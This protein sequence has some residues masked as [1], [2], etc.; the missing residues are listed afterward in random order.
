[1]TAPAMLRADTVLEAYLHAVLTGVAASL[2]D[3]NASSMVGRAPLRR[4]LTTFRWTRRRVPHGCLGCGRGRR[5]RRRHAGR[6]EPLLSSKRDGR[7]GTKA[8][9]EARLNTVAKGLAV[10]VLGGGLVAGGLAMR[11]SLLEG[12]A[13]GAPAASEGPVPVAVAPV[14]RGPIE[15][16]RELTGTL[17]PSAELVVASKVGGRIKRI[18]VDLGDVVQRG[19]VVAALDDEEFVQAVAQARAELAVA[20]AEETAA[21]KALEIARRNYQRV[22]G[23]HQRGV[24]SEQE[25]DTIQAAKLDAEAKLAVAQ[26][27]TTRAKAA[28]KGAQVREGYTKVTASWSEGDTTRVVAARYADEGTTVVANAPLLSIVDL[29][30]VIVVVHVTER[31][32]GQ[33]EPG[34]LVRL[35]TDAFPGETFEGTV[36]RIAPVFREQSRQAR[37]ELQVPNP[38]GRLKPGMFVRARTVLGRIEDATIVPEDALV[39]RQGRTAV[40]VVAGDRQSVSLRPVTVGFRE[41][42]RV[43]VEG[44]GITGE[45]VTLGQQQLEDGSAITI[46]DQAPVEAAS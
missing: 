13:V 8:K 26:S 12:D 42:G 19:Q 20:R 40:F 25:L 41:E 43:S 33:L 5:N 23:L 29:D 28:L 46:P 24:L 18:A 6:G 17:E 45:V 36:D 35:S 16:R 2:P 4:T 32:Y 9:R 44:E 27:A 15:R 1:M 10:V 21:R 3:S 11:N 30:P 31:D 38:D 7:A 14:E 37:V 34:Q 22:E 39:T